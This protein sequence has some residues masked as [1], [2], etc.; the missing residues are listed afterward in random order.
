MAEYCWCHGGIE[1]TENT[2]SFHHGNT[3]N[4]ESFHHGD[5]ED[6]ESFH[7]GGMESINRSEFNLRGYGK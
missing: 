1:V 2:E 5:T 4:I 7:H 3:E 6:A